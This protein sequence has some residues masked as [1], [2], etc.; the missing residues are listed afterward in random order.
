M[1]KDKPK[2]ETN[3]EKN[4]IKVENTE[5]ES[6]EKAD[7]EEEKN[8]SELLFSAILKN[9][10]VAVFI[11]DILNGEN[12]GNAAT[13]AFDIKSTLLNINSE[14]IASLINSDDIDDETRTATAQRISTMLADSDANKQLIINLLAKGLNFEN[15]LEKS[16]VKGR[17]EKIET[18]ERK[19]LNPMQH[20]ESAQPEESSFL[21]NPRKSIWDY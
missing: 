16:Y 5:I 4:E 10:R 19:T 1:N 8:P 12:P 18:E 11:G 15:A 6:P 17:N 9:P 7:K 14:D 13:K 2:N 3:E 20:S 21:K